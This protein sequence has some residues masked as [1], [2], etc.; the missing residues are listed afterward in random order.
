MVGARGGGVL[1]LELAVQEAP[2]LDA[3]RLGGGAG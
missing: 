1:D 2:S 3:E